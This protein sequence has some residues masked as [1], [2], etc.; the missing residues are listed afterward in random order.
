MRGGMDTNV[1][2]ICCYGNTNAVINLQAPFHFDDLVNRFVTRH[3]NGKSNESDVDDEPDLLAKFCPHVDKVFLSAMRA[4]GIQHVGQCFERGSS[5]FRTILRKYAVECEFHFKY[6][7][8]DYVRIT[9]WNSKHTCGVAVR[10]PKNSRA[11]SNLLSD[12][13]AKRVRNKPLTQPTDVIYDL[14]KYY[15]LEVSYRVAWLGVEKARGEMFGAH[16]ISFDQLRWYSNVVMDNNPRSYINI[17]YDEQN[18]RFIRYFISFKACIDGFNHCRLLLFLDKTFLKGKFKGN[19]LAAT[20]KDGNQAY[21]SRG[22]R[23]GEMS[24]NAVELFNSWI[25]DARHLP[26]TQIIDSIQTQIMRQMA[27]RRHKAEAWH[28]VVC[29]KMEARLVKMYNKVRSWLWQIKGFPCVHAV[30][31][32]RNNNKDLY[33]LVNPYYHVAEY[34]SSYAHNIIPIPTIEKPPFNAEA[35]VIQPPIVK[36]PPRRPKKKQMLSRG[37][38]VQQIRCSR[39]QRMGNHNRKTCKEP[40]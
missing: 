37:E 16:S 26:I 30:V 31:A 25:R 13:I 19:L 4:N 8:N 11:G 1:M 32:I 33:E 39:C 7:K 3:M 24:S 21:S 38:Q 36:R 9:V 2:F 5:E 35:F 15:E 18:N 29:S 12:V 40:I 22:S 27:K 20:A 17:D 34:R 28:G 23:Y 6:V 14:K 10:T